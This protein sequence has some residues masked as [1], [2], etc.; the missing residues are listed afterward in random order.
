MSRLARCYY[1]FPYASP[2]QKIGRQSQPKADTDHPKKRIVSVNWTMQSNMRKNDGNERQS[3]EMSICK[4]A[5]SWSKPGQGNDEN[6][7][8]W[9]SKKKKKKRVI[10]YRMG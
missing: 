6:Y 3:G 8:V 5:G 2:K 4:D 1:T 9:G 10:W 7:S